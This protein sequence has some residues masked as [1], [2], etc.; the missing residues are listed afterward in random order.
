MSWSRPLVHHRGCHEPFD[1]IASKFCHFSYSNLAWALA[2]ATCPSQR[3]MTTTTTTWYIIAIAY[4]RAVA[5]RR[6]TVRTTN[7]NYWA[8]GGR[9]VVV[10][11]LAFKVFCLGRGLLDSFRATTSRSL[12]LFFILLFYRSGFL[13]LY[14]AAV[15][16][17]YVLCRFFAANQ[18]EEMEEEQELQEKN[19]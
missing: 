8:E 15:V 11:W 5:A 13:F 4:I 2:L 16:G 17:G 18:W 19:Y 10:G 9:V 3:P 14:S 7:E 12:S 6:T 1:I